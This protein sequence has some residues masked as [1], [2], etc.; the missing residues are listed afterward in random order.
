MQ[1]L[2]SVVAILDRILAALGWGGFD[3]EGQD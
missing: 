2:G 1:T 3:S